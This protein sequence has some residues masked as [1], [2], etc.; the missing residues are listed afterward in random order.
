MITQID[1]TRKMYEDTPNGKD[2]DTYSRTL[3][4][5]HLL[6]WSKPL[7]NGKQFTL[8]SN[9]TPPFNLFHKSD[10]GDFRLSSD[11]ILHT[12]TRW[13]RMPMAG[14]IQSIPEAV[15]E[16]FYD[17]ASTIGGYAVFPCNQIEGKP[18]INGIR[19]MNPNLMDRF[20]FT[21]ECI[22]RWYQCEDSPLYKHI[23]RYDSFF[24]LFGDF[25]GY[26]EFFLLDD[27][28][29]KDTESI[30]FW[31]PFKDFGI[32][33][34]L[35]ADVSEYQEYMKNV[36]EFATARGTRMFEYVKDSG[37]R[38]CCVDRLPEKETKGL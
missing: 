6:L 10:M 17:Q 33:A 9:D 12:Y 8:T 26:Y 27:L 19:G 1:T 20:D 38:F 35:P 3:C 31:L 15:R 21:L 13:T 4:D 24:R 22:R 14:I 11:S 34:P 37:G 16:A 25:R 36:M 7:P 29:Q 28:V 32:T 18:T 30:R 23:N 2:P 5:Y